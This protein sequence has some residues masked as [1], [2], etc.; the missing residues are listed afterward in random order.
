MLDIL[1]R[2]HYT[3]IMDTKTKWSEAS[4]ANWVTVKI[5][6]ITLPIL[7]KLVKKVGQTRGE[8]MQAALVEYADRRGIKV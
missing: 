5:L 3:K 4:K 2:R 7:N 6:R 1:H 8:I